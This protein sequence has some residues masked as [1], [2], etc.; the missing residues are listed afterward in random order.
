MAVIREEMASVLE[1][2]CKSRNE[3][4]DRMRARSD[5]FL[6]TGSVCSGD[7]SDRDIE[8]SSRRNFLDVVHVH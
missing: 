5:L 2:G 7:V 6:L 8:R 1:S 3:D 4:E